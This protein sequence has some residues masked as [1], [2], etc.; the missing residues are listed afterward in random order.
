MDSYVPALTSSGLPDPEPARKAAR[1][2][3][4]ITELAAHIHAATF[5]LLEKIRAFDELEGWNQ[6][7][8]LSCAHWLQWQC[9][10]NLGAARER[11]RVAHA[12]PELPLISRSFS[13]GRISYSKVRAMTRVATP[14]NEEF[15]LQ[16]A[17]HGTAAHVE[18]VVSNYRYTQRLE[19]L[20]KENVRHAQRE[21]SWIVD[22]D[23]MWLFKGKFTPEQGALIQKALE[24]AMDE[25]FEEQRNEP[26]EVSAET[27]QG[28][29][30]IDPRPH[31]VASRRADA[32]ERIADVYLSGETGDRSGGDRCLVNIHTDVE[33]LE[34]DGAGAESEC[35]DCGKVSA[36][37][38]RRLACDASVVHWR[39]G[40][41]GEPLSIGRKSRTVPPAIRRALKRRDDG[42]R[43][44]GCSCRRFVDAH[45]IRHWA[46]GGETS[47]GN[48]VLL[49]RRHHRLVHEGGFGVEMLA[50]SE[51][52][53]TYPNGRTVQPA[54]DGHF[55]GNAESIRA[56]NRASGLVITPETLTPL[57]L[58]ER[59]DHDLANLAMQSL[60]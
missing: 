51:P 6:H 31:P 3:E 13:E 37:T 27:P 21:L 28:V 8:V 22:H 48:L 46:D 35:G 47:L 52:R 10:M 1:L 23:G 4:E 26:D 42:C 38:S 2:A 41:N 15:L 60:E 45:H 17:R 34:K 18:K 36:E 32:L 50:N 11:I 40:E 39:N 12:L 19:A 20:E 7:G 43:F 55:R 59:M 29:D 24:G 9:G 53:F 56:A 25:L 33:T 14:K 16:I 5:V 57:W 30:P 49:C 58:G 54:P 44:P